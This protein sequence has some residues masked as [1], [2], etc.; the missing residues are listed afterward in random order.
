MFMREHWCKR[1]GLFL[2]LS[3]NSEVFDV[4]I[5]S[6]ENTSLCQS[7][8]SLLSLTAGQPSVLWQETS[9]YMVLDDSYQRKLRTC[10]QEAEGEI[11]RGRS[12]RFIFFSV[13]WPKQKLLLLF[14]VIKS[15]VKQHFSLSSTRWFL[16]LRFAAVIVKRQKYF[17]S[18]MLSWCNA[19]K[20]RINVYSPTLFNFIN[21]FGEINQG[22]MVILT[23]LCEKTRI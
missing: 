10:W 14:C 9:G 5:S 11:T 13:G 12:W 20:K 2:G 23:C 3:M 17:R 22:F 18:R 15:V 8:F 4:W 19:K 1:G 7:I 21:Y 16:P 6:I